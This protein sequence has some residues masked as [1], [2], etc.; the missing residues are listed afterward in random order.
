MAINETNL[1]KRVNANVPNIQKPPVDS[2]AYRGI[3]TVDPDRT[4]FVIYDLELIKQDLINHF[5]ISKG[6]KLENPN[7]GTIIWDVLFD[8]LTDNLKTLIAND[9]T[10]IVN[11]DPRV[12]VN[13]I[14]VDSYESGIQIECDLTYL[15]YNISETMQFRFDKDNG[16]IA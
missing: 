11:Y 5:H 12:S 8:P 13:Q 6:E 7:F 2:R 3:S 4:E 1:V 10:T 16:I 9:V 14:T 15:P